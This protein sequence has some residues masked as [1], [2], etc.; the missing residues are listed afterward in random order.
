MKKSSHHRKK[1]PVGSA[2]R[3]PPAVVEQGLSDMRYLVLTQGLM[4]DPESDF[5]TYRP[6]IWSLLL[7]IPAVQ[8]KKY[9]TLIRRGASPA[10]S[11][12]RNDT[13]RTL[14]TD[15]LFQRRVSETSLIRILNALAWVRWD[16]CRARDRVRSEQPARDQ[17][18][19]RLRGDMRSIHRQNSQ[20]RSRISSDLSF[21]ASGSDDNDER[22]DYDAN[23][24]AVSELYVQGLNVLAAPFLYTCSSETQAFA[25]FETFIHHSCPQYVKPMLDGVHLGLRLLDR[26]LNIVD[27]TLFS[28]LKAKNM[29]AELYA[30]A[31]VLTMSACTPPL[32]E[33][34]IL[35]DF[36]IAYGPHLNVLAIIAQ[37]LLIRD[38]LLASQSPMALLRTFPPLQARRVISLAVSFVPKLPPDIYALLVRHTYDEAVADQIRAL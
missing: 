13:F 36:L 4:N 17:T 37:L 19:A 20:S 3:K 33:V 25:L 6:Y 18:A 15:I 5:C 23:N 12:I 29:T 16:A 38:S 10:Y 8:A 11:K 24:I 28:T 1:D 14:T 27:P 26:C 9:L 31:S 7:Q 22:D 30:F 34:L 2:L 21:P 35:W 32:N